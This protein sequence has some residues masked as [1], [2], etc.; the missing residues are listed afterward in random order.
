MVKPVECFSGLKT[1]ITI[2]SRQIR[3]SNDSA[4]D[5]LILNLVKPVECLVS[6]LKTKITIYSRQM[7][8]RM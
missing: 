7:R 5:V 2:Y 1:K 6:G 8:M 4:D 3:C